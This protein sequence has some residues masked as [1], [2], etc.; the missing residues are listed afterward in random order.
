MKKKPARLEAVILAAG[1]GKRLKPLTLIH[2]KA[3]TP[4]LGVPIIQI[5]IQSLACAGIKKIIVVRGPK[6]DELGRCLARIQKSQGLEIRTCVQ[7]SPRGTAD[8]LAAA[9][10][11]IKSDF[12]L[13]GCDNIFPPSHLKRLVREWT[14]GRPSAILSLSRIRPGELN[15]AAGV[16]LRG[17]EVIAIKEKPG[18]KSVRFDAISKF[19]FVL[20]RSV[21]E[22]IDRVGK[23]S[24]GEVEVQD[25][26][27]RMIKKLRAYRK[28]VGVFAR[29]H[30]HLTDAEDLL[31]I[32]ERYLRK[33][34]PFSIHPQAKIAKGV[35]IKKPVMIEKGVVIKSGAQIG[36]MVYIGPGAKIGAKARVVRCVIYPGAAITGCER[37]RDAV[38]AS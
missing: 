38:I 25:A 13:A 14:R 16:R 1:S 3:M 8:A 32:H 35:K 12:I 26:V 24:R 30:L 19:L 15:R 23:S 9:K 36:P 21:L 6:D 37:R 7:A 18:A 2:S 20:D 10:K 31:K 33:R 5:I 22:L 4:I 17:R 27:W 28:P 29:S 34:R 11:F